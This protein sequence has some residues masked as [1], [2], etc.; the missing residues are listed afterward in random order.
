MPFSWKRPNNPQKCW[1]KFN[2]PDLNG[3]LVEYRIEDLEETRFD[4]VIEVMQNVHLIENQVFYCKNVRNDPI[5]FQEVTDSWRNTLRQGISLVCLKG[6]SNEIVGINI[7][8]VI[9]RSECEQPHNY[10]GKG[11]AEINNSKNY[12]YENHFNPFSYY[13]VKEIMFAAGLLVKPEYRRRG[14]AAY[15][16]QGREAIG[17]SFGVQVTSTIFSSFGAQKAAQKAGYSESFSIS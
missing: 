5:S 7:L 9:Q 12:L 14:I 13:K 4:E 1:I 2:A 8:G 16:L 10:K 6:E 3:S 11:W 15:L 17:Q